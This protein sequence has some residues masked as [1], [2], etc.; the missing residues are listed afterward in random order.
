MVKFLHCF[1]ELLLL[2]WEIWGCSCLCLWCLLKLLCLNEC[3]EYW[4]MC[5]VTIL[6]DNCV[7]LLL[8][9][10]L[11]HC[12]MMC[13]WMLD[14]YKSN[15]K[16]CHCHL[17]LFLTE[18]SSTSIRYITNGFGLCPMLQWP[19]CDIMRTC[20]MHPRFTMCPHLVSSQHLSTG[21]KFCL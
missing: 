2:W 21:Q 6:I 11:S 15:L 9:C 5:N 10:R 8:L 4:N 1:C 16:K 12:I 20:H 3:I 14:A 13:T 7:L 17:L 19:V 18:L